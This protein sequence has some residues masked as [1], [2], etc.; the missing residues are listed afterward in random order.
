M[1]SEHESRLEKQLDRMLRSLPELEAP[2]T[3]APRVMAAIHTRR[4]VPWYHRSWEFWPL[5]LRIVSMTFLLAGF[6]A[7][8]FASW[9][10]TQAAGFTAAIQ[11]V[12][13][14]FSG[15]ATIWRTTNALL[16]AMV[17]VIKNLSTA[18][19]IALSVAVALAYAICAGLGT[20]YVRLAMARN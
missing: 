15:A 11:E 14:L 19:L 7:L 10:L 6:S 1:N 5:S 8:C 4:A 18:Y 13:D 2:R 20:L 3:L 12:K 9:Q 17:L 16:L